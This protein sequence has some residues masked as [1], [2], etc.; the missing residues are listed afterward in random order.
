MAKLWK[1]NGQRNKESGALIDR[2]VNGHADIKPYDPIRG[3]KHY[4]T[5]YIPKGGELEISVPRKELERGKCL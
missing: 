4:L 2:I 3:A 5:K 1:S